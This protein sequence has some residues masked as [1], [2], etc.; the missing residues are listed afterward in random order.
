MQTGAVGNYYDKL[1]V[2]VPRVAFD[3]YNTSFE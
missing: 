2:Y 3:F 1:K